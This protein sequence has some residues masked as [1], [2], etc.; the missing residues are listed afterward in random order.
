MS[1]I[2]MIYVGLF[3][4][5]TYGDYWTTD[6]A[7]TNGIAEEFNPAVRDGAT[8][9]KA[10]NMALI[11]LGFLLATAGA[12]I[13]AIR[14][15]AGIAKKYLDRPARAAFNYFYLNPF[16][17]KNAPKSALHLMA[18]ALCCL[19]AKAFAIGSNTVGILH[20][21]GLADPLVEILAP[22]LSG[23]PLYIAVT[24]IIITPMWILSLYISAHFAAP[25]AR[26]NVTEAVA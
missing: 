6:F 3:I 13:W 17:K 2:I 25:F 4:A 24:G 18:F 15:R 10:G 19:F 26:R 9:Y 5:L 7:I 23:V 22:Y 8:D 1:R 11:N 16:S 14:N 12:L 20:G 21:R